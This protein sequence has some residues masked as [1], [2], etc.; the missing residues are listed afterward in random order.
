MSIFRKNLITGQIYPGFGIFGKTQGR[1]M[2]NKGCN[3]LFQ[4]FN[5][6]SLSQSSSI[7]IPFFSY[8]KRTYKTGP[9]H[10][11]DSVQRII[12]EP[13][14]YKK[15][16]SHDYTEKSNSP[17]SMYFPRN[18]NLSDKRWNSITWNKQKKRN[19]NYQNYISSGKRLIDTIISHHKKD[20]E[21]DI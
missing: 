12:R 9:Q 18:I 6:Y 2:I 19:L 16:Q 8:Y 4:F 5:P 13:Q 3:W 10:I 21:K 7:F 14:L 1:H 20:R 11:T 15:A 17:V